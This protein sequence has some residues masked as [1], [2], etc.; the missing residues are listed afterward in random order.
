MVAPTR[1]RE[2]ADPSCPARIAGR[3]AVE[4]RIGHGGMGVVFRAVDEATGR[5]V[6]LKQMRAALGRPVHEGDHLRLQREFHTLARLRHPNLVE[7]FDYGEDES[8]PFY[9]MELL[10][11]PDLGQQGPLPFVEACRVLQGVA[12]A[13]SLLHTRR[14]VHRDVTPQN[15]FVSDRGDVKLIDFGVLTAFGTSGDIAGTPPYI[16][17]E[18]VK[19]L[20]LDHRA[21]LYGLG[22]LAYWLLTGRNAFPVRSVD[23]LLEAWQ[24]RPPPPSALVSSVPEAL[25]ALVMAL[26]SRE[27][28]AR[29]VSAGEVVDR[30]TVIGGLSPA[31]ALDI[32]ETHLASLPLI[33]RSMEMTQLREQVLGALGGRGGSVVVEGPTGAGR[34]RLLQEVS[35][36]A[37]LAG[38]AVV[39]SA[40]SDADQGPYAVLR[41]LVTGLLEAL[42]GDALAA[43]KPYA[44]VIARVLPELSASLDGR[45]MSDLCVEPLEERIRVQLALSFWLRD[46]AENKPMVLLVDDLHRCD[47]PSA[48]VLAA[49]SEVATTTCL[50]LISGLCTDA[51]PRAPHAVSFVRGAGLRVPLRPFDDKELSDLVGALFGELRQGDRLVRWLHEAA[52]GSPMHVLQAVQHLVEQGVLRQV[53]GA[54]VLLELPPRDEL[55]R[56]LLA[57]CDA[58]LKRLS[59]SAR[60]LA[61]SLAVYEGEIALELCTGLADVATPSLVFEALEELVSHEVL[62]GARDGYRFRHGWVRAALLRDV[63]DARRERLHLRIAAWLSERAQD[64]TER[65]EEIGWHFLRGGERARGAALLERAGRRLFEAQAWVECIR[66]LEAALAVFEV[67]GISPKA[68]LELKHM[69]LTAGSTADRDTALKH[70]DEVL[71]GYRHYAGLPLAERL[72]PLLGRTGSLVAG[73]GVR[74][75]ERALSSPLHKGP[76]PTTAL[77]HFVSC[78]TAVAAMAVLVNDEATLARLLEQLEPL[79][80]DRRSAA[81][82]MHLMVE[83]LRSLSTGRWRHIRGRGATLVRILEEDRRSPLRDFDRRVV[84]AM[85]AHHDAAVAMSRQDLATLEDALARLEACDLR[86]FDGHHL[87]LRAGHHRLRGEETLALELERREELEALRG[88]AVWGAE[89][90]RTFLR[91]LPSALV[92]DISE[93]KRCIEELRRFP[94][95][96]T[97]QDLIIRHMSA[98]YERGRGNARAALSLWEGVLAE[99]GG[100]VH[101]LTTAALVGSAEA[102]LLEGEAEAAL[103]MA[104]RATAASK[105]LGWDHLC[106]ESRCWRAEALARAACGDVNGATRALQ[107]ELPKVERTNNPLLSGMLHE[108]LALV[109]LEA[110]DDEAHRHHVEQAAARFRSTKNPCLLARSERLLDS[111]RSSE[112]RAALSEQP[113]T[114]VE[115]IRSVAVTAETGPVTAS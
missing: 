114:L 2:I 66:P 25:D 98:E 64:H 14:L 103:S 36:E 8:G 70:A 94:A 42:P 55:P 106:H 79:V 102:L 75:L 57:A 3:Y 77:V 52:D 61:E 82:A 32:A 86:L 41:Q 22:A 7:V 4:E 68:R 11:G 20:P 53:N 72:R 92:G 49:V 90:S 78:A 91:L 97:T 63:D 39:T 9:T 1:Q 15:V 115:R 71:A 93:M 34:S 40:A 44:P 108:A 110:G 83:N 111:S 26:L 76:P 21:D 107:D 27:P 80:L 47:E 88:G 24:Q 16:A 81:Y 113:H 100:E 74:A 33:G 112:P 35:L 18:C 85:A 104:R 84:S 65:D 58:R 17:P 51:P 46:L 89:S 6:A 105:E 28:L 67:E 43:A 69:L 13:L 99:L 56:A 29:P 73:L 62:V 19:G 38:A 23:E 10:P 101:W 31:P 109:A 96:G 59:A 60:A 37:Q 5:L 48:A 12:S 54:W 50:A 87:Q 30:L 95:P 45:E